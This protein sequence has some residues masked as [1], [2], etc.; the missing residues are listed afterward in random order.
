[1]RGR[2]P[3]KRW[4]AGIG[5]ALVLA[6]LLAVSAGCGSGGSGDKTADINTGGNGRLENVSVGPPPGSTYIS[7][8]TV[9]QA[10]WNA[11]FPPPAQYRVAL[12]RYKENGGSPSIADQKISV[13]RQGSDFRWN[14]QRKDNF[15]LDQRGVYYLELTSPSTS[16]AARAAYIVASGR[17]AASSRYINTGGN[18]HLDGLQISPAPGSV[19]IPRNQTF[20]ISWA[21]G[22]QPPPQLGVEIMRY[23]EDSGNGSAQRQDITDR[24][25]FV[26]DVTRKDH[27]DLDS[28]GVYYLEI[29]APGEQ[30]IRAAYIVDTH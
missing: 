6:G 3:E 18:G 19:F 30:T 8:A 28:G 12:R 25:G 22:T 16:L 4:A 9:F 1:M 14:I 20:R 13:Q 7:T 10:S 17:T 21:Q 27:F 2:K 26:Y 29:T 5:A 11:N 24:G 15:D 23:N